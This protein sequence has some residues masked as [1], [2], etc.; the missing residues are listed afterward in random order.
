MVYVSAGSAG[1]GVHEI[2]YA[3]QRKPQMRSIS[4]FLLNKKTYDADK[5]LKII[6]KHAG[7]LCQRVEFNHSYVDPEG[8][9]SHNYRLFFQWGKLGDLDVT[10]RYIN[11][12]VW[13]IER[14]LEATGEFDLRGRTHGRHP[15]FK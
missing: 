12:L 3:N 7:H 2:V 8:R 1:H 9:L 6:Y 11:E 14:D 5:L 13:R 10:P 15:D 4:F